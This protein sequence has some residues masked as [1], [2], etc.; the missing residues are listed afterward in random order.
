MGSLINF[1]FVNHCFSS[2]DVIYLLFS[3]FSSAL[4][5]SL[6]VPSPAPPPFSLLFFPPFLF[7][8]LFLFL[9]DSY[10]SFTFYFSWL[11]FSS[12]LPP[13]SFFVFFP[14]SPL[15]LPPLLRPPLVLSLFFHLPIFFINKE[16]D[17]P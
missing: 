17:I 15:P 14:S 6:L 3:F 13:P 8:S 5:P 10:N 2:Y 16:N 1:K 4:L 9:H 11:S 12:L 7:Y